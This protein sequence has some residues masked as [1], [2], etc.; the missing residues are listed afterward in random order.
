MICTYFFQTPLDLNEFRTH[1]ADELPLLHFILELADDILAFEGDIVHFLFRVMENPT[2]Y[3][4]S[5]PDGLDC[6]LK[7]S[8]GQKAG[9]MFPRQATEVLCCACRRGHMPVVKGMLA[10]G[11]DVN[12]CD[13]HDQSPVMHASTGG[14][15]DVIDV[16]VSHGADVN[17]VNKK[18][19]T[20][21]LLAC[22]NKK[23]DAAV[24]LYQHIMALEAIKS[25]EQRTNIDETFQI[26][27]QHHGV[28]YLQHVAE[29]DRRAYDTLVSKFS[30]PDA[31]KHGYDLVAKHHVNLQVYTQKHIV[32]VVKTAHSNNQS[33]VIHALMPH[34]TNSSLS[35]LITHA[36]QQGQYSFAHELFESCK[37]QSALP[38]PGISIAD[39]CKAR[40]ADLVEFL[41]KHDKDVN[42]A[43]DELGYRLKYL[44]DD[45][46]SLLHVLKASAEDNQTDD[47]VYSPARVGVSLSAV[48]DHNCHPPLVYA[49]MQGDTSI[50]KLLLQH[51]ADVSIQSDHT[52]LTAACKH[53]H[54]DVVDIILHNTP[55]PSLFQ[56]NMYGMTPLQVAVKCHQGAIARRLID[57]YKADLDTCKALDAEFIEVTLM[58]QR[59]RLMSPSVVKLKAT[60]QCIAD[61]VPGQSS[62]EI[63]LDEI[64]TEDAGTSP[65]VAAFQSKQYDLVKFFMERIDKYEPAELFKHATL[66]DICQ[67]EKV[68]FVKQF[69]V[70]NQLQPTQINYE[71]VLDVVVKLG[72]TDLMAFLLTHYKIQSGT[73]EKAMIQACQRGSQYMVLFLI[74]HDACLVRSIQHDSSKHCQHPLCIAIRKSDVNLI[75][76][77]HKSGA[78]LFNVSSS[79]TPRHHTL[80]EISLE[81]LCTQD[82]FSNILP[83][84]LPECIDQNSLTSALI[85]ACLCRCTHAA[86][87]LVSKGADVNRREVIGYSNVQGYS[88]IYAAASA[89]SSE[90]VTLLLNACPKIVSSELNKAFRTA[91]KNEQFEI[92]TKLLEAGADAN[93]EL[94]SPLEKACWLNHIDIVEL[95]LANRADS[96]WSSSEGPILN[97]AHKDKR[98]EVVRL[99][100]EYGAEPS[101]LRGIGLKTACELGYTEVAQHI[102]HESHVSPDELEQCIKDAY[103]NG[104]LEAILEAIMDISE[105]D[106]KE[107]C[108]HLVHTLLS[109]ETPTR[110][111]TPQ[112]LLGNV[113]NNMSLWRCLEKRNIA[114]MRE[115]IKSGINVNIP[116]ASGRSL[117]QECIQQKV[118]HVIPDLCAS[119][120]HIDHRDSAGR[121]ALFY[122]L[123]CLD[124][125]PGHSESISVYEYLASKGADEN[126]RDYFGRSVLHEWQPASDGLKHGPTLRRL[127]KHIDINSTDHKEQTALHLAV[128]NNNILA[129]RQL[130]EH[131]A[132]KEAHDINHITPLFLAHN[133]RKHAIL[134]VLQFDYPVHEYKEGSTPSN[135]EDRRQR[136]Y[137]SSNK[138]QKHRLVPRLKEV[139]QERAKYALT[140]HFMTKYVN[141]VYYT[142]NRSI[143]EEKMLFE[144]TVLQMLRDI[145]DMVIQ[146]EPMLSFKPRLSGSCAEGTKVI[147][148]DEAD[149]LCVFDDD[150]WNHITLSQVST[151]AHT[152]DNSSFVQIT[153][154]STKHQTL[155]NDEFVSKRKMLY[156][157]YSLIRKAL[158]SVLKNIKSLY[159]IDVKNAV[160]N[161]HSLACLSMVWHGQVLP[162]QE[163]TVDIVPA[164]PVRQEQLP[165]VTRQN[166]KYPD[167]MQ[168]LF[169]VPKTGTF[170]QSQSDVA[171]RVSF[172][173]TER[174]LFTALPTALKQGYMLT[175]VLMH[176][177][178]IIDDIPSG[179]C[180]YN[181]K[182]AAF[183]CFKSETPDWE[184]LVKQG[185]EKAE[186]QARSEDVMKCAQNILHEVEHCIADKH[187]D[188][189]FL[190]ECNLIQHS[191][192]KDDYRQI[193][194]M[195][196]CLAVLSDTN[197]VA[198]EQLAECVAQQLQLSQN[199]REGCFVHEVDTLLDMGLKSGLESIL[200]TMIR[201]DQVEGVRMML[202]S[203]A[204][205]RPVIR[206][207][208][209]F[210]LLED[211]VKGKPIIFYVALEKCLVELEYILSSNICMEIFWGVTKLFIF[212]P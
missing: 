212:F 197:E 131:G 12:Q 169:L 83:L 58:S 125:H 161:D 178:I 65:I 63:F 44:P 119:H 114:R 162:W 74:E 22:E 41:I 7:S 57:V 67:L 180:S 20:S 144:E 52:P 53:G 135:T 92:A 9:E 205:V 138:I 160:A 82:E 66:E 193:L 142:M 154:L 166:M 133:T 3:F 134:D 91:C 136:V 28:K 123:T 35:E 90:V 164:I 30:L 129:V 158:P 96:N 25:T 124:I 19:Q 51:G 68:H 151:G 10:A 93:P 17:F 209:I 186:R 140:D 72:S 199:I 42:N 79:E 121:T 89:K 201:L 127:L 13:E 87:L 153:S 81:A 172:S 104:F 71:L 128:L 1:D 95:L 170:D 192:D 26:A 115:L 152:Q 126:I 111:D 190:R 6:T 49:C 100:L 120:I 33:V 46:D 47:D 36:Y 101:V 102:I 206:R 14:E 48:N 55:N 168:D 165:S 39:A 191:I 56:T 177:C 145:N 155:V 70:H 118:I 203:G 77:L 143:Q 196:Y 50:V 32:D 94:Y 109:V 62:W 173:S 16:L 37:D 2:L 112:V 148:L 69:I 176:D 113:S 130:L 97:V 175:K 108:I 84:L 163:F 60:L 54:S 179:V 29:N 117:L 189:F 105:Q 40:Q 174:N 86:Q 23:W 187:Q 147:A 76:T 64:K 106:V 98:Y 149:M 110:A 188:S 156:R 194:C 139:C 211:N 185:H 85:S 171:F 204:S 24:A 181:L 141:R 195:K 210:R 122:S 137:M 150:L 202:E 200:S 31:C 208:D 99:L 182:T 21:L 38:C 45:A 167:I 73:L 8:N 146:E 198:W 75:V 78:Q 132:N 159:M 207:T 107:H 43:A 34:L 59:D 27:L 116:N 18:S 183:E 88:P 103:K 15:I 157:L 11:T 80:C 184:D 5:N 61:V 4:T